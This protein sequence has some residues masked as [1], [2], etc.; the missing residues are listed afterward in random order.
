MRHGTGWGCGSYG[1]RKGSFWKGERRAGG[2]RIEH[3]FC[4]TVSGGGGQQVG[5]EGFLVMQG[6]VGFVKCA[7]YSLCL[8]TGVDLL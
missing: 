5:P 6:G 3:G 2:R 1:R 8:V 4:R 7:L